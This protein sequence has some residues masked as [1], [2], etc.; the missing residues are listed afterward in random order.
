MS[1]DEI[2][3]QPTPPPEPTG[4]VRGDALQRAD[5]A[6]RARVLGGTWEQCAEVAGY[7]DAPTCCRAVRRAY[8]DLPK[9][10]RDELR[11]LWRDRYEVVGRQALADV[12]DRRPGAVTSFVRVGQA[13]ASLDGL[14]APTLHVVANPTEHDIDA[15]VA[16]ALALRGR[17]RPEEADIFGMSDIVDADVI[18]DDSS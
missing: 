3:R 16:K 13:A 14:N 9:V 10:E 6:W 12:L 2:E 18:E 4:K 17:V 11:R 5:R 7:A 15:W 1:D 8:D